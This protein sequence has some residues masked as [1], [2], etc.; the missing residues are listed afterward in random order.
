MLMQESVFETCDDGDTFS[1]DGCSSTCQ[2]ELIG[3]GSC[4]S[5]FTIGFGT[6]NEDTTGNANIAA[7]SCQASLQA[8]GG[9]GGDVVFRFTATSAGTRTFSIVSTGVDGDHGIILY[10]V[11]GTTELGCTDVNFGQN[12][13]ESINLSMSTN[14]SVF[15]M[16]SGFA[17]A[18]VGP[19][20]L[21][22]Q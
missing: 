8:G 18:S 15:V 4:Q 12:E 14:Q 6:V 1:G 19:F 16:I 21:T 17:P 22:I 10:S 3:S 11:C 2:T 20:T 7:G 9:T 5:P 13:T